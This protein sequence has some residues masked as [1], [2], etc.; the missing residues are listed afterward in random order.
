MISNKIT[1]NHTSLA[2][3]NYWAPLHDKEDEI[4]KPEQIITIAG[5]QSLVNTKINKWTRRIKRRRA[6]KLVID[7]GATSNFVPEE[8]KIPRKGKSSKEVYLPDNSTLQA[9]YQ[10]ELPLNQLNEKAREANILPGLQT[11]LV[12]VN[13]MA[14]KGYTTIFHHGEEGV[15]VHKPG[16]LTIATT[17]SP[18][19]QGCKAKGAKLWTV[20]SYKASTKERANKVYN[21][22]LISQAVQYLHAAV[23]FPTEETWIKAIKAGNY[24]TWPTITPTVVRRHFPESDETQQ[25]H[26]K[27]QRQGV[28]STRVQVETEPNLPA[29]PKAKEVYIKIYNV[30]EA[31]HTNQTGRFPATSSRGNQYVMVLIEVDGNFI[32]TEPTKNRSEGAMI[33]AYQALW[34]RLTA[35]G[36]VNQRHTF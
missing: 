28:Q 15:T 16:T 14:E 17:E 35:S 18:I 19:L 36:T 30:T 22:P 33:K 27:R 12:S 9:T 3:T 26:M 13:K 11:Q 5:Q 4:N 29:I 23:G 10:A 6:M 32:D 21:L 24:N 8:I 7:S 34:A 20:V 2:T 31:M 1:K 25:G